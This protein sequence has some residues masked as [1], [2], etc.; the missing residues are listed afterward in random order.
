MLAQ[1]YRPICKL[2]MCLEPLL[3]IFLLM[4]YS[5]MRRIRPTLAL[6]ML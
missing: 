4:R 1:S 2:Q 6:Q 5:L 3:I